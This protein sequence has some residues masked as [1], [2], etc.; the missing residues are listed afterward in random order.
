MKY[1]TA[2]P[3]INWLSFRYNWH[4]EIQE[5]WSRFW[6]GLK[7]LFGNVH[8][9]TMKKLRLTC[10]V[11]GVPWWY[12][13]RPC[14]GSNFQQVFTSWDEASKGEISNVLFYRY[15]GYHNAQCSII[16]CKYIAT[17]ISCRRFP[18]STQLVC[19]SFIWQKHHVRR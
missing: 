5:L 15:L 6:I 16:E 3:V 2:K 4:W 10:P 13:I 18:G 9:W 12:P 7:F 11:T 1:S 8:V 19:M 14:Y 17:L